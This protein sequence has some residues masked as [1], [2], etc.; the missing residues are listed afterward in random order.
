MAVTIFGIGCGVAVLIVCIAYAVWY[1]SPNEE[2][3]AD[4][5]DKPSAAH[6]DIKE[7]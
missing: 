3:D 4:A 1:L 5:K 2:A 7:H 6:A